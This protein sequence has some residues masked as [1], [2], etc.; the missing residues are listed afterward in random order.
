VRDRVVTSLLKF[1]NFEPVEPT[2]GKIGETMDE[3]KR[4][5]GVVQDHLAKIKML[6]E[7][8]GLLLEPRGSLKVKDWM[9]TAR[10]VTDEASKLEDEY[11]QMLF[12]VS[13]LKAEQE[14]L[15]NK[16]RELEPFRE[17]RV[18]PAQ[19]KYFK[20]IYAYASRS[21]IPKIREL[22]GVTLIE[23][24]SQTDKVPVLILVSKDKEIESKLRELEVFPITEVQEAQSPASLYES[25]QARLNEI[26]SALA[27]RREALKLKIREE[28]DKV[29]NVYGS[30]LTVLDAM[31][32]LSKAA[33][34]KYFT[35][36][37][38][39]VPLKLVDKLKGML[40]FEGVFFS[41]E[42]PKFFESKET[43]PTYV[44]LPKAI[45]PLESII[46]IYGTPSYWE[47]SPT[48]FLII[49]FPFLFGLM[50]PDFGNA[51]VIFLFALWF[52]KYGK[53][54]GSQN[55]QQLSLV[56]LYSSVVA[57]ITGI[58]ERG[59]F[60]PLPVGGLAELLG[61]EHLPKGPL[62]P[63]WDN[64]GLN[65]IYHAMEPILPTGGAIGVINTI[66]LSILLGAVLLFV[67]SLLGVMNAIKKK[68]TEWLVYEK[69]PVLL[70]YSAPFLA[71]MYGFT[72][73]SNFAGTVGQVLQGILN[74]TLL[75]N[76]DFSQ[77]AYQFAFV[78]L[79]MIYV[80]LFWGLAGKI[81]VLKK[82]EGLS[83]GQAV[84][85]GFIE[86]MFEPALLLLSNTVSFIRVLVFALAHYY[87]LFAFSYM[88][89]LAAGSPSDVGAIFLNPAAD[90]IL[91]IGN[92]LAIGLEG[93]VVF[94][95]DMRL[96]FYEMFSK[97]YE[98]KGKPFEPAQSYVSLVEE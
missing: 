68:D 56:L 58:F 67:S 43:P 55:I 92:L 31:K 93:L 38:G 48:I 82:H 74:F 29:A 79:M 50:F 72:N 33:V 76:F 5:M 11:K 10:K 89:Y 88:A 97:F 35:Q 94:I 51:L 44:S 65:A 59:F 30:L 36:F 64:A 80:G 22:E 19:M 53:K 63:L 24:E 2:E 61:N 86:G 34:S 62:Y 75:F 73:P 96:H 40:S 23:G 70:L 81:I 49:T 16:L 46:Q 45:R 39:Y 69:L 8:S 66:I 42:I 37:V 1:G 9:E 85:I 71:F 20:L 78:L 52:R 28:F 7:E 98:G 26:M 17:V 13:A 47:I 3:P 90:A 21:S 87:V 18:S 95:Q 6:I 14:S 27:E 32:V 83:G 60:G 4:L 54:K 91:V 77:P 12:E 25:L 84:G 57:M 41:Y 15:M